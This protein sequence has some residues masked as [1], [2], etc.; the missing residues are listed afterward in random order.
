[1][2]KGDKVASADARAREFVLVIDLLRG[3]AVVAATTRAC[4]NV[5]VL[6][7]DASGRNFHHLVLP[8]LR[9]ESPEEPGPCCVLP[10]PATTTAYI[11][12]LWH[13]ARTVHTASPFSKLRLLLRKGA[14]SS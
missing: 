7:L 9:P 10:G 3:T 11:L 2:G 1:M 6:R 14:M 12:E 8:R 5:V 13:Q 4:R